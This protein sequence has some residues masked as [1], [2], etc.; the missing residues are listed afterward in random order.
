MS[1][2]SVSVGSVVWFRFIASHVILNSLKLKVKFIIG[3][4]QKIFGQES[5]RICVFC[6]SLCHLTSPWVHILRELQP[7]ESSVGH[8]DSLTCS[9]VSSLLLHRHACAEEI[10]IKNYLSNLSVFCSLPSLCACIPCRQI[11]A[12]W[13]KTFWFLFDWQANGRRK[14]TVLFFPWFISSVI[15]V[16][17]NGDSSF[18]IWTAV[19]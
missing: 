8:L 17:T 9:S 18:G 12:P 7:E 2:S 3:H 11:F 14:N 6:S 13:N 16:C 1:C 5:G 10:F 15:L 19:S 4:P